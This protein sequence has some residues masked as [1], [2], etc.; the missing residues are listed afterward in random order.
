MLCLY[1]DTNISH[2]VCACLSLSLRCVCVC[3]LLP[4]DT[5]GGRSVQV[6]ND[7]S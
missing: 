3:V 6:T 1:I 7:I 2:S 4:A 5:M